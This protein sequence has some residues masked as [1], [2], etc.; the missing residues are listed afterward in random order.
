MSRP[1]S[2]FLT[3]ALFA[4]GCGD[5]TTTNNTPSPDLAVAVVPDLAV[6][7]SDLAV[8]PDLTTPPDFVMVPD[9]TAPTCSDEI[10][11]AQETDVDCGGPQC[12][13]C[14]DGQM[15]KLARDC[16]SGVCTAGSCQSP[17][18]SDHVK[19]GLETDVDCGGTK[20]PACVVGKK[21]L[22]GTDCT[23]AVCMSSTCSVASCGD[24]V[25]N[26]S[27]TDVDCG[28][29]QCPVCGDGKLCAQASDCSSGVCMNGMCQS[30]SCGDHVKNASETDVDCGGGTCPACADGKGCK[31]ASDCVDG[32]CTGGVCQ[33]PSCSDIVKNGTETDVDCGGSCTTPCANGKMCKV[34]G[35]CASGVC[36][37]GV[38]AAP[39]CTDGVKNGNETDV[40]CGGGTCPGCRSGKNCNSSSDCLGNA[41]CN[42]TCAG[43]ISGL[44]VAMLGGADN[45]GALDAYL[46]QTGTLTRAPTDTIDANFLS[47]YDVVIIE[48]VSRSYT[49]D[50]ANALFNWVQA[51]GGVMSVSGYSFSGQ[52]RD[53]P[54]SLL[55][56]L[57]IQYTGM[58]GSCSSVPISNNHP[59]TVNVQNLTFCGGYDV[60]DSGQSGG[61]D[62]TL[63]TY[64]GQPILI[65]QERSKGRAL[66]WG[67]EWILFDSEFNGNPSEKTFWI[68]ALIWL[69]HR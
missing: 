43:S 40:D 6:A 29:G 47:N 63:A 21:C 24:G 5:S 56:P 45:E 58:D 64:N 18:C 3:I 2:H 10:K 52:D 16:F 41:A 26:A 39:A 51:G 23:T 13:T 55:A 12:A 50:E 65:A 14:N 34:P 61:S 59:V 27:E 19:N 7:P 17:T 1:I 38:C 42:T 49:S 31:A 30:A 25:K 46:A 35:D 60:S 44:R 8:P 67:D 68:Q 57:G 9:L 22:A 54:N 37:G 66:V 15:C 36:T 20:C 69:A 32:V 33:A 4:V 62:T 48:E 28:G 53:F 11:N